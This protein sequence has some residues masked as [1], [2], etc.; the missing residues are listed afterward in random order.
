M[1]ACGWKANLA[2]AAHFTSAR[3]FNCRALP[4]AGTRPIGLEKLRDVSVLIVD[5]NATNRRILK[6][7]LL[8]WRM[9]T[10]EADS[11]RSALALLKQAA[12]EEPWLFLVLLDAQ[13][14]EV[15]GF[16]VAEQIKQDPTT[17]KLRL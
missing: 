4:R 5:D 3:V 7:M 14:P 10:V 1:A 15:D 16:Q 2:G 6:E 11:G 9:R 13:M 12:A 8:G 17:G